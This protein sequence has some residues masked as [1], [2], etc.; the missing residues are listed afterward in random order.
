MALR[1]NFRVTIKLLITE[2]DCTRIDWVVQYVKQFSKTKQ[3]ELKKENDSGSGYFQL[4]WYKPKPKEAL[5]KEFVSVTN[6]SVQFRAI[7]GDFF[8]SQS[9]KTNSTI[10]CTLVTL[11]ANMLFLLLHWILV[12]HFKSSSEYY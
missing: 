10:G 4:Y 8:Q 3:I 6:S 11:W 9:K 1:N 2:S 7:F 12:V 5:S